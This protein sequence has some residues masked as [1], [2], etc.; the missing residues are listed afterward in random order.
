[1]ADGNTAMH[2]SAVD[3]NLTYSTEMDLDKVRMCRKSFIYKGGGAFL[4]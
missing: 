1:M 2:I 4:S 3:L